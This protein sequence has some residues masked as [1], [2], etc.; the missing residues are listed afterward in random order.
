MSNHQIGCVVAIVLSVVLPWPPPP[1]F[2]ETAYDQCMHGSSV[3]PGPNYPFMVAQAGCQAAVRARSE[4]ERRAALCIVKASLK[5]KSPEIFDTV[6]AKCYGLLPIDPNVKLNQC[7]LPNYMKVRSQD[8][9][10]KIIRSCG[11]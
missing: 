6:V 9:M 8:E 4:A 2:A 10:Q 11:R 5:V 3:S 7:I 1:A